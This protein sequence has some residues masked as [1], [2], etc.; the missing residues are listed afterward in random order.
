MSEITSYQRRYFREY[1]NSI[2]LPK[3]YCYLY[4][5]PV[6]VMVPVETAVDGV[7]IV[8]AYPSA[9]FFTIDGI[10][11]VPVLDN[12]A[13]FSTETYFDGSRVRSVASG[14]E[15]E[16]NYLKP[17]D[18][19]RKQC[20]ITDLVKVFLFKEGHVKR[21]T[22]LGFTGVVET[23]S[24]FHE[25]ARKSISWLSEEIRLARP[26]VLILLGTEVT[27]VLFSISDGRA[28]GY[29]DGNLRKIDLDGIEC[30]VI[31]LPHPGILMRG[32]TRNPWP[33]RFKLEILP[34]A[35]VSLRE[36]GL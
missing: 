30:Q 22:R 5:N 9:K 12:D 7:M 26:R 13:P 15:L 17:L 32:G 11:D 1:K 35:V 2:D 18:L 6:Q 10:T 29:L 31:C 8:G 19:S 14:M 24:R 16:Q 28:K 25:L 36:L 34:K 3:D 23:R 21:Y 27:G 20:W 4:G 33:E